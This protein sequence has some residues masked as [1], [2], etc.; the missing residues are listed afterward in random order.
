VDNSEEFKESTA[1]KN[2]D[3][4]YKFFNGKKINEIE[5]LLT[6]F[7]HYFVISE[8]NIKNNIENEIQIFENLNSKGLELSQ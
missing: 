3:L 7:V 8:L 2:Y 4:I 5:E 1:K 6:T